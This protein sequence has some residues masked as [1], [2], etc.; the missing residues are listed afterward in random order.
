MTSQTIKYTLPQFQQ[1]KDEGFSYDLPEYSMALINKISKQVGA[2]SYIKTPI[3]R[4]SRHLPE[5]VA[6]DP[7]DNPRKIRNNKRGGHGGAREMNDD[8]W[9]SVRTFETTKFDEVKDEIEKSLNDIR[10]LLN[11]LSESTY[12]TIKDDVMLLIIELE[13]K[14]L[15]N[16][17]NDENNMWKRMS[18]LIMNTSCSNAFYS[19]QYVRL[20]KDISIKYSSITDGFSEI[21]DKCMSDFYT[22][23]YTDPEDDYDQ[24]CKNNKDNLK[25]RALSTFVCNLYKEHMIKPEEYAKI[26]YTLIDSFEETIEKPGMKGVCEE[27]SELIYSIIGDAHGP[28]YSMSS[29]DEY[30]TKILLISKMKAKAHPSLTNKAIFKLCDII[31]DFCDI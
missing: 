31:D 21:L 28:V 3:F 6:F 27:F 1:I 11:K 22:I 9:E 7:I 19:K 14:N 16:I 4:K 2:P 17:D 20:L 12:D 18:E 25:R 29:F 24:F 13:S 15:L 8:E 26:L 5:N 30:M 23:E 10:G